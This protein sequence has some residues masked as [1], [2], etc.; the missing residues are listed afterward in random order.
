MVDREELRVVA[1]LPAV[2]AFVR[3][4]RAGCRCAV[5]SSVVG[6]PGAAVR[7]SAASVSM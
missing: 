1:D 4:T 5:T 7:A 6:D 2:E 3:R